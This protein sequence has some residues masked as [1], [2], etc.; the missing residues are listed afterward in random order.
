MTVRATCGIFGVALGVCVSA[1]IAAEAQPKFFDDDPLW[2]EP[3]SQNVDEATRYEPDLTYLNLVNLFGRP[4]DPVLGQRAKNVNTVDEVLD[5]AYYIN[6]AGRIELTPE[7]VA[8]AANTDDGPAPGP[9]TVISAKSDGITP[10]FTIRDSS[11]V[12]WFLK[13]DPPGYRGMATG[14]EIVGAKLFWALGYHTTEYHL[15][16]LERSKLQ[17]AETANITPPGEVRRPMRLDDI[18]WLL[19]RAEPEP[20]GTF[21]VIA[22]KA[23]P[24][25]PVGRIRFDGTRK[26][27]PNDV[28]PH[29]HR[30]ELRGYF[31]FAAWLNHVDAKDTNSLATLVNENG[32]TYI[33]RHLLDFGSIL[34]SAGIGPREGWQGY[35]TLVE[36]PKEILKR[37]VSLGL[38]IP[39]WRRLRFFEAPSI[40]RIPAHHEAWHPE[41]WQPHVTNAAFRHARA[42]DKFWAASKLAVV[43]EAMVRAAVAE[44]RFDDSVGEEALVQM[45][46]ERRTRILEAY[47][48][49]INPVVSPQLSPKGRLTFRNLAVDAGVSAPPAGYRASWYRFDNDTRELE[50]LGDSEGTETTLEAPVLP[51]SGFVKVELAS[52][53]APIAAWEEPLLVYFR[54]NGGD[55]KLV[56]L[57]RLPD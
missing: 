6:R 32:R 38:R 33:R 42:D 10:G 39:Q 30:R 14:S 20:D 56:G 7:I 18:D 44:G 48:P 4:G 55:W 16:R 3:L 40:G 9:W 2:H 51:Q 49:A 23:A 24:G 31:V 52:I 47:L 29:E 22:S 37:M 53:G 11:G 41:R 25:R 46:L 13:F 12:V 26:D 50:H 34:G 1:A 19:E 54:K 45:I 28:V 35:E 8:R 36:P 27:D 57:E 5:G 43:D 15:A 21:R 17:I